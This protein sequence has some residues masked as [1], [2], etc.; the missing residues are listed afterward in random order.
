MRKKGIVSRERKA[1]RNDSVF[2][3]RALEGKT[4]RELLEAK[5]ELLDSV[6]KAQETRTVIQ[7][8]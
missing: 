8:R 5:I 3:V 1:Y 7:S 4:G 2:E 6:A